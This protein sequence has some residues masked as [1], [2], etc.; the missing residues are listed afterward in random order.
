MKISRNFASP[1]KEQPKENDFIYFFALTKILLVLPGNK[2]RTNGLTEPIPLQK[3][4]PFTLGSHQTTYPD[5]L[6]FFP[7]SD[8]PQI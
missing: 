7:F 6:P 1:K 4:Q 2:V 8:Y 3:N 5:F